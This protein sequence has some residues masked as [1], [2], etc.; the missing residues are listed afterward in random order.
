MSDE[1]T[2]EQ[3]YG[4]DSFTNRI[5]AALETAGFTGNDITWSDLA[6]LDQF[7]TRGL[8]ASR[9]LAAML[10]IA[11]GSTI[12]DVGCG[13]GGSSRFLAATFGGDV[14][15]IDLTPSF[16][17]TAILLS[18]R[19]GLADSTHFEVADA[20]ALPFPNESFD[21]AWTQ[22]VAMNIHDRATFYSE[23]HRVLKPGG[24]LAIHD[25]MAGPITPLHFPVPWARNPEL[26]YLMAPD[27]MRDLLIETGFAIVK[28]S[29]A[30][31]LT[32]SWLDERQRTA[33]KAPQPGALGLHMV[34]G[35]E[36]GEMF[37]NL[38]RNISEERVAFVQ[39]VVEKA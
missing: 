32:K 17:E 14:T 36:F 20:L 30:S 38:A 34:M 13:I 6:P 7:H 22:H 19:T 37:D 4:N 25:V 10:E 16:I 29:D 23:I 31:G 15:G 21:Y 26:S 27:H 2:V 39:T 28:W 5:T 33:P 1:L 8:P 3:H 12:L 9:E 18:E 35:P 11:P 24:R